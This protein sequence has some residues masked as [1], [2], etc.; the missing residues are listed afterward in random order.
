MPI[1][2]KEEKYGT[3]PVQSITIL[4]RMSHILIKTQPTETQ[5]LV[6]FVMNYYR[7]NVQM[8]PTCHAG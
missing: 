2:T 3:E 4:Q 1:I 8:D 5:P 7:A 6:L